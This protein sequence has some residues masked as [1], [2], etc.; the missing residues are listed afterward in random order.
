MQNLT[1]RII[2]ILGVSISAFTISLALDLL[3][4][5]LP[6]LLQFLIQV[7]AIVLLIEEGRTYALANETALGLTH[8]DINGAF[9]FAA[10]LAALAAASLF[11][12][13]RKVIRS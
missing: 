4:S 9:F 8:R 10:P 11:A 13:V 6:P 7:P 2:L 3:L 5:P 12:D 1:A